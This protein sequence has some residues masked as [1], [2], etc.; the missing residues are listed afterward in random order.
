MDSFSRDQISF[1][2]EAGPKRKVLV[3]VD[4]EEVLMDRE[5]FLKKFGVDGIVRIVDAEFADIDIAGGEF[6]HFNL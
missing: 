1:S 4:G 6:G 2:N 5:A 3:L